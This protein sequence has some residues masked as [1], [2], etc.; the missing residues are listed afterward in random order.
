MNITLHQINCHKLEDMGKGHA[1]TNCCMHVYLG[2]CIQVGVCLMESKLPNLL[3]I[4]GLEKRVLPKEQSDFH[5]FAFGSVQSF[6]HSYLSVGSIPEPN[7][8][9]PKSSGYNPI[10]NRL[11][12]RNFHHYFRRIFKSKG[13][14]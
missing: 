13:P 5:I 10:G 14:A 11:S 8:N 7:Q 1:V 9:S 6:I 2:E 3:G 4:L 12:P